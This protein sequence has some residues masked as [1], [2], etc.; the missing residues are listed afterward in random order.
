LPIRDNHRCISVQDTAE[1]GGISGCLSITLS[2]PY[3]KSNPD[4]LMMQSTKDRPR[5]DT[6]GAPNGPSNRRILT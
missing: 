3:R 1:S 2:C 4:V 6:P 5:F